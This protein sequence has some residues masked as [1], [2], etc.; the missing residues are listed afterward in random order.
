[1]RRAKCATLQEFIKSR[2]PR[3]RDTSVVTRCEGGPPVPNLFFP[4]VRFLLLKGVG[5]ELGDIYRDA[6][7]A[8]S[9]DYASSFSC[10]KS[11]CLEYRHEPK[12]LINSR[13]VQTNVPGRCT[14]LIP[15]F[16]HV[17]RLSKRTLLTTIEIGSSAG[18]N[19]LW[20]HYKYVY[21]DGRQYGDPRS[22]VSL[23]CEFRGSKKPAISGK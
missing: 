6:R 2:F 23:N 22:D 1:M 8:V 4:G 16:E 17:W 3:S 15:V 18:L 7:E 9:L 13:P 10:F 14:Y 11:F 21:S 20:D 5:H 19:L 12:E